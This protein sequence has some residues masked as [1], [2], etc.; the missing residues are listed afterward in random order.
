[1]KML[2]ERQKSVLTERG[3]KERGL[4]EGR[5]KKRLRIVAFL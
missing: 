3:Q 2:R 4:K 1:M 5:L